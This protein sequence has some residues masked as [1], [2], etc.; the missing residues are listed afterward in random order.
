[1]AE[2]SL[3]G[4]TNYDILLEYYYALITEK[5]DGFEN[6]CVT[7]CKQSKASAGSFWKPH[8]V[9]RSSRIVH[10]L[11]TSQKACAEFPTQKA[12]HGLQVT[13]RSSHQGVVVT[14]ARPFVGC[15]VRRMVGWCV[16][17]VQL[18]CELRELSVEKIHHFLVYMSWKICLIFITKVPLKKNSWDTVVVTQGSLPTQWRKISRWWPG[19]QS[20]LKPTQLKSWVNFLCVSLTVK[21]PQGRSRVTQHGQNLSKI[22]PV[23]Y[24]KEQ[25]DG[26]EVTYCSWDCSNAASCSTSLLHTEHWCGPSCCLFTEELNTGEQNVPETVCC[27]S[28][29]YV[30]TCW[31]VSP[32]IKGDLFKLHSWKACYSS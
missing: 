8:C 21:M 3:R 29:I 24:V 19:I 10:C 16:L 26:L 25:R 32:F 1:M 5:D 30:L 7:K 18:D 11:G 17:F 31:I 22:H 15:Q 9:A 12:K 27:C 23:H 2:R 14:L 20:K 4:E 13:G 6:C 28:T